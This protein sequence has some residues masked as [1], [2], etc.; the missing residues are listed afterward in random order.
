MI[1]HNNKLFD[2]WHKGQE[3][4]E[5]ANTPWHNFVKKFLIEK[6]EIN[7]KKILEIGCGRGGLSCWIAEY[8]G[9]TFAEL[10]AGDFSQSALDI[11]QKHSVLKGL[12][13]INWSRQDIQ[14][15]NFPN[16]YFD[17][18]ISCETIE[19]VPNPKIAIKELYRVC[20]NSGILMLTTP[21]YMNFYG[22]Y[23][24]YLRLTGRKWTEI[25]QP[26]NKFVIIPKTIFW[27]KKIGFKLIFFDSEVY[28]TPFPGKR[29]V[30]H[31]TSIKPHLIF[32]WFGLQSFFIAIKEEKKNRN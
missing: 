26:I 13:K 16:N 20:K 2:I 5:N 17:I 14:S 11:A 32:K 18:V 25:G 30:I 1:N 7:N 6:F 9:Q 4:D 22:L 23:R 12:N 28:S 21:N 15:I 19:H 8:S 27:L 10:V 29:K 3:F 24:F 31:F